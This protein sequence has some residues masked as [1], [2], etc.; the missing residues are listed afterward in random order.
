MERLDFIIYL[1]IYLCASD[2]M[3]V[4]KI[5]NRCDVI[6]QLEPVYLYIRSS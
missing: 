3:E 4:I 6:N 1:F 2:G 5:D